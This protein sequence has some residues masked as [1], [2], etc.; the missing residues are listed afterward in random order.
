MIKNYRFIE[1]ENLVAIK[2]P[3]SFFDWIKIY[4]LCMYRITKGNR[5]MLAHLS[6]VRVRTLSNWEIKH[7]LR[8]WLNDYRKKINSSKYYRKPIWRGAGKG[9]Y[10]I[11]KNW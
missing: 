10:E 2:L 9:K 4:L 5:V 1:S 6:N 8:L 7:D 11:E 3:V